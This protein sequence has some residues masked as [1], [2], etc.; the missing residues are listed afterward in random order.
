M[1]PLLPHVFLK[2]A[3]VKQV[4]LAAIA[5]LGPVLCFF[6]LG[7]GM[8]RVAGPVDLRVYRDIA[9]GWIAGG[10]LYALRVTDLDLPFTYPPFA[11]LLFT[12]L[13][14]VPLPAT[15]L[16]WWLGCA[17][18]VYAVAA[19]SFREAPVSRLAVLATAGVLLVAA[20]AWDTMGFGQVNL[21]LLAFAVADFLR[22]PQR[23]HGMLVGLAASIK[24]TPAFLLLLPLLRRDWWTV[25][26]AGAVFLGIAAVVALVFPAESATFFGSV[27]WDTTRPGSRDFFANQSLAGLLARTEMYGMAA[28]LTAC[29]VLIV[30]AIIVVTG[31]TGQSRVVAL[32][33]VAITGLL[34]SPVS[35]SHHWV[36][37]C[38][39][40]AAALV[41][42]RHRYG[43]EAVTTIAF[44]GAI[45]VWQ[46]YTLDYITW[47]PDEQPVRWLIES[48]LYVWA[49]LAWLLV[50]TT[51][52]IMRR[53]HTQEVSSENVQ[54]VG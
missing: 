35:W 31:P 8:T 51:C 5:I 42:W 22:V 54:T 10:D 9:I 4:A 34:V 38:L 7:E 39:A 15:V 12:P 27:L 49:A 48:N 2:A 13:S 46:P 14:W 23:F 16:A 26:R 40:P 3:R 52:S 44:A 41:L 6:W 28:W 32:L 53:R 1:P 50:L 21:F 45:A 25:A 19:W 11:A 47:N 20:P 43:I 36:W 24:I 29:A 30:A 18:C 37:I 33:V 17:A